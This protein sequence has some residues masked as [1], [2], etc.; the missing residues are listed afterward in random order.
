[1]KEIEFECVFVNSLHKLC[2]HKKWALP[3]SYSQLTILILNNYHTHTLIAYIHIQFTNRVI[4]HKHTPVTLTHF[5]MIFAARFWKHVGLVGTSC[6]CFLHIHSK[7]ES[8]VL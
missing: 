7:Y 1:M 5:R 8:L 3:Y 4:T 6:T 2:S